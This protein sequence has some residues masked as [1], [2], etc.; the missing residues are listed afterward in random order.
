MAYTGHKYDIFISYAQDDNELFDPKDENSRWIT[1]LHNDIVRELRR[2]L[3]SRDKLEIFVDER[4]GIAGHEPLSE[5]IQT[6]VDDAA[7]LLVVYSPSYVASGWC[8]KERES[9]ITATAGRSLANK[10]I[11]LVRHVEEDPT[12]RPENL[13]DFIGYRFCTQGN[14][15]RPY[16]PS[17]NQEH[18]EKYNDA[19]FEIVRDLADFLPKVVKPSAAA[20]QEKQPVRAKAESKGTVFVAEATAELYDAR[21]EI[22]GFLKTENYQV[23]PEERYSRSRDQHMLDVAADLEIADLFV[24]LVNFNPPEGFPGIPEGYEGLQWS[25]AEQTAGLESMFW[26]SPRHE[27]ALNGTSTHHQRLAA[28]ISADPSDFC[29]LI[30]PKIDELKRRALRSARPDS[31]MKDCHVAIR[32]HKVDEALANEVAEKLDTEDIGYDYVYDDEDIQEVATDTTFHGIVVLYGHCD[33]PWAR[34]EVRAC[35][36]LARRLRSTRFSFIETQPPPP[37]VRLRARPRFFFQ[38]NDVNDPIFADFLSAVATGT[39]EEGGA[40]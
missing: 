32:A 1:R 5:T 10:R 28:C 14:G 21:R 13:Q 8:T 17:H 11:F 9:F 22:I 30:V 38:A 33:E 7:V 35:R 36:M 12:T 3:G 4:G 40:H 18:K 16:I 6:A 20:H 39:G 31:D 19:V 27:L 25:L 34:N 26:R 23:L 29:R 15:S 2:S 24:G 37:K